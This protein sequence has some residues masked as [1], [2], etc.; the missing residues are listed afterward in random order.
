[1]KVTGLTGKSYE[2]KIN[3]SPIAIYT[4]AELSHGVNITAPMKGPLWD[5]AMAVAQATLHRQN[6]HYAKWRSV[7]LKDQSE[8]DPRRI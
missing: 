6:A 1:M 2:L 7:W 5:Q 3:D 8:H 4:T